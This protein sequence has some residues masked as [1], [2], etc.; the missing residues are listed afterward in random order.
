MVCS[1]LPVLD[2][3]HFPAALLLRPLFLKLWSRNA[4]C[5]RVVFAE[6][7]RVLGA[8]GQ[9]SHALWVSW[10]LMEAHQGD[11]TAVRYLFKRGMD[12]GPRSR[13]STAVC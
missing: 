12:V 10:A 13:F 4:V 11:A 1:H 8:Q 6:S 2:L 5:K 7:G 3:S 9:S